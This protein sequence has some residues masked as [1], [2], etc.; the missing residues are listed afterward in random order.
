MVFSGKTSSS[1]QVMV[2][3]CELS[4]FGAVTVGKD[5]S[6]VVHSTKKGTYNGR[7]IT[8]AVNKKMKDFETMAGAITGRD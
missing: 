8:I 5:K 6:R 2:T 4:S 1:F 7:H 3:K